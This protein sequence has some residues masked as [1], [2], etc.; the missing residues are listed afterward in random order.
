MPAR[1]QIKLQGA[2]VRCEA[3]SRSVMRAK[4]RP[5]HNPDLV[6]STEAKLAPRRALAARPARTNKNWFSQPIAAQR[7]NEI[8]ERSGPRS[9]LYS[10]RVAKRYGAERINGASR[11]D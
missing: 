3:G 6:A 2:R 1:I 7:R 10:Q 9:G 11:R 4:I 5:K 8:R